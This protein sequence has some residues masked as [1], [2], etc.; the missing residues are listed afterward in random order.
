[1]RLARKYPILVLCAA[2]V[3]AAWAQEGFKHGAV[4]SYP[5]HQNLGKLKIAAVKY[6]SDEETRPAFGKLNPNEHG[7]L[8]VLLI[9]ENT[10]DQTLLLDRMRVTYQYPGAE[11]RA[12]PPGDLA[13]SQSPKKPRTGPEYRAPFPLPKK[14]NPMAAVELQTRA[15]GAKTL[16]KGETASG[17]FYFETRHYRRAVIYITGIREAITGKELFYAEV[18]LDTP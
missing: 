15:F 16:L 8:P 11:V 3:A 17:F 13:Y 4:A 1:M 5:S 18:P 6:E 10:S 14:K 12:T 2:A 7:F 9:F